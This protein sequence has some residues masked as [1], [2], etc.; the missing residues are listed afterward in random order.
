MIYIEE[1]KVY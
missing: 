1:P